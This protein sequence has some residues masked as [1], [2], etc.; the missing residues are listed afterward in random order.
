M[1]KLK[2]RDTTKKIVISKNGGKNTTLLKVK[3]YYEKNDYA[4]L[5]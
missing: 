3:E 4:C 2:I 1:F 5:N